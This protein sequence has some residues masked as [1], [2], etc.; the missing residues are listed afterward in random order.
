[1]IQVPEIFT[2]ERLLMRR[3][4]LSDA[5]AIYEYACDPEVTRYMDWWTHTDIRDSVA[6]LEACA[7]RWKAGQEF[8]GVITVKPFAAAV[9]AAG[10]PVTFLI[11]QG[12]N[13][14]EM[15]ETLG[16][17]YGLLG[18]AMLEQMKLKTVCA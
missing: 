10:K 4:L 12:Y 13:H 11:G 16:N 2:T 7:P 5:T 18:R 6:F 9:K 17:P 1:M 8:C 15:F 3:P 14:F